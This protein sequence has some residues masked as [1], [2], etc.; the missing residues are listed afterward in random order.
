M[1]LDAL[2]SVE[3]VSRG[4]GST[5]SGGGSA[6]TVEGDYRGDAFGVALAA[7]AD[8]TP[9]ANNLPDSPLGY[10][11]GLGYWNEPELGLHYVRARWLDNANG[12]WL[13]VDPVEG[14]PRY[15][16]AYNSPLAF[17]DATGTQGASG[18][19]GM[20][21]IDKGDR[22]YTPRPLPSQPPSKN[23]QDVALMLGGSVSGIGKPLDLPWART[24]TELKAEY[25]GKLETQAIQ[26]AEKA[27]RTAAQ[28]IEATQA[29]LR[30]LKNLAR[31]LA[32]RTKTDGEWAN[33]DDYLFG[34]KR[35]GVVGAILREGGLVAGLL[36]GILSL[37]PKIGLLLILKDFIFALLDPSQGMGEAAIEFL[38]GMLTGPF[39][40]LLTPHLDLPD[41]ERGFLAGQVLVTALV[42]LAVMLTGGG[43]APLLVGLPGIVLRSGRRAA[44]M[45]GK[46]LRQLSPELPVFPLG[47]QPALAVAS[48]G[49]L[50]APPS[51]TKGNTPYQAT[52]R[53]KK[54]QEGSPSGKGSGQLGLLFEE[55]TDALDTTPNAK[56]GLA[57]NVIKTQETLTKAA[58]K[59][60]SRGNIGLFVDAQFRKLIQQVKGFAIITLKDLQDENWTGV[61]AQ[62]MPER[63]GSDYY[64]YAV[65]KIEEG[66]P[67]DI[68][69]IGFT[70]NEIGRF[71]VYKRWAQEEKIDISIHVYGV[72]RKE[73]TK[74]SQE[75]TAKKPYSPVGHTYETRLSLDFFFAGY[76]LR[77][78]ATET[79][80]QWRQRTGR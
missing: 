12:L 70:A 57:A 61:L 2:G 10:L 26:E 46:K 44:I 63:A 8:T 32:P 31:N 13:S 77:W 76:D 42:I 47:G 11:G 50:P 36:E 66:V 56:A 22:G 79:I 1:H 28:Q 53:G 71:P 23:A 74:D 75:K 14:E 54:P 21:H 16:Y 67:V 25:Y 48:G 20:A 62:K 73:A 59:A 52:G 38:V 37:D 30:R 17:T 78:D 9:T 80:K 35:P 64:L 4:A 39:A 65:L 5:T 49:S 33:L 34:R 27:A 41:H 69:K 43:A 29:L 60:K 55:L 19:S 68:L 7:S 18:G 72:K 58:N 51:R 24:L 6:G 15:A 3:A 40:L 45:A